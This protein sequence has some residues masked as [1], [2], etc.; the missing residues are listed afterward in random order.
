MVDEVLLHLR[1]QRGGVFVD[2]TVGTGGHAR[3]LLEAGASR[4][5][6]I[7]RDSEALE[8]AANQL[9]PLADRA[10]LIHA[11]FRDL[12]QLLD[13]RGITHI[14]GALADFGLSSL[15]LEAPGRGFSFRRA[16]R[17]ADG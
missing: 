11:D 14:D 1:P 17:H 15:Q 6:G 5:I 16:P 10:E 9:G 2:C 3:R 7:D 8:I 13:V 4:L 12:P